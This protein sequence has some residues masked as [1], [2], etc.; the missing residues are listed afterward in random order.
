MTQKPKVFVREATGLVREFGSWDSFGF[1]FGGIVTVVALSTLFVSFN[2]LLGANILVSLVILL[3]VL[4]SYYIADTQLGISMPRSGSDYV[5]TSRI[6]HPALGLMASWMLVFLLI[7]NPAIF[8]DLIITGYIPGLLNALG[9]GAQAAWFTD[10]TVRF[11]LDNI[12]IA[13]CIMFVIIPI[14]HY[15]KLQTIFIALALLGAILVPV[16]LLAV[17]HD[18][19]VAAIN[20]RSAVPYDAVIVKAKDLGFTPYF[21]WTDTVLAIPSLGFYLIT[22]WP[23]TVGGELKNVRRSLPIGVVGAGMFAWAIF[24]ITAALYYWVLGT[25]FASAIA[26]L[27]VNSPAD[28]PFGVNLLTSILQYVYGLNWVTFL[29]AISLIAACFIV[30]AQSILLS[31][32]HILAWSFDSVIP[33]KFASISD[34]FG[35]PV[36]TTLVLWIVSEIVLLVLLFQSTALGIW[37]NAAVGVPMGYA[38]ALFAAMLFSRRRKDLFES[39]PGMVRYK[40]GGVYAITILGAIAG[41]GFLAFVAF[42]VIF[43]QIGYPAT[44]SNIGFMILI[45]LFGLVVYYAGKY[46]R[47]SKGIDIELAFRQIPPE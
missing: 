14:R 23:C 11:V 34:R 30:I 7:L 10:L 19:F 36:F 40:I 2:F 1:N 26:F 21:S 8:S 39:S 16:A 31:T 28:S 44:P 5:Y 45:Y 20:A 32:R 27:A 43:P 47:R 3:P 17:G 41:I 37:L 22:N 13:I 29:V 9:M 6:L 24:F 18:G 42:A 35:T 38:P 15:A 46:Y 4:L 25:D 12:I 33:S